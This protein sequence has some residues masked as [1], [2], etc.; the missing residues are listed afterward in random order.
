MNI[1]S[2]LKIGDKLSIEL[3]EKD[4][5]QNEN[6]MLN[7]QLIDIDDNYL[8][9]TPPVYKGQQYPLHKSQDITIFFYRKKGIYQFNAQLVNQLNTNI[10][11]FVLKPLGNIQKIQ[12]RNYYRLPIVAPVVL[13]TYK[14]DE[15]FETQ[16]T[17]RDLSGGGVR[18]VCKSEI[19]KLEEITID[20][21]IDESQVITMEGQVVRVIKDIENNSYELGIKFK[22]ANEI[23]TEKIFAFIFEKQR[24]MRKKGLI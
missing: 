7:S 16:C 23:N 10:I 13:K 8:Y 18:V 5:K 19:E 17:M 4:I 11:I 3:N 12:R 20:L 14:N 24:L 6:N 9:V 22:Q 2:E 21:F 15:I 1:F